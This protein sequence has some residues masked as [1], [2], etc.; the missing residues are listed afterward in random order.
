MDIEFQDAHLEDVY[1]EPKAT[2]GHGPAVDKG[3]RKVVGFIDNAHD[4]R[5]LRGMKG[6]HYE[7]LKGDR[8]HQHS[9]KITDKWRLIV[10]RVKGDG[11]LR[12]LIISV[13]DYH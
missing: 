4:E 1:Y 2:L 10:E 6:L 9:L 7:K 13:V 5:D 12:L 8:S 3:F 11:S